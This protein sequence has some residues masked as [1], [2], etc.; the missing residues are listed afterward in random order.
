MFKFK[1]K[2]II[3]SVLIAP[4]I[5]SSFFISSCSNNN[6]ETPSINNDQ[7]I[8][9]EYI[10]NLNPKIKANKVNDVSNTYASE[11]N[12][13]ELV[14]A[15]FDNLP[16]SN[17]EIKVTFISSLPLSSNKGTLEIKYLISKGIYTEVYKYEYSG[18]KVSE[19]TADQEAIMAY[20]KNLNPQIKANKL[21]EIS[22][23]YASEI[24]TEALVQIWFD[25]LPIDNNGIRVTFVSSLDMGNG[26]LEVKYLISKGSYTEIYTF[27]Q[28]GFKIKEDTS[29][30][31]LVDGYIRNLNPTIKTD[32]EQMKASTYASDINSE[33]QLREWFDG[34]PVSNNP[35]Q[36]TYIS[37]LPDTVNETILVVQY[38]IK[39]NNYERIYTFQ[40]MG[41][42]KY[43]TE[44][45]DPSLMNFKQFSEKNSFRMR[46]GVLNRRYIN[47]T[48]WSWYYK[49]HSEYVYDWYLMTNL[50]VVD[51]VVAD[52]QGLLDR[53]GNTTST[54]QLS[55]YYSN[56]F[57]TNYDISSQKHFFDL[58]TYNDQDKFQSI[59]SAWKLQST[60]NA[61]N[62]V[63]QNYIKSIDI[64]TD[65]KNDKIK[66][67][68]ESNLPSPY[69]YYNLDMALVKIS[70]DFKGQYKY[71]NKDYQRPN[72]YEQYLNLINSGSD[73]SI[74]FD[75]N[76]SIAGF[77]LKT[78]S[79]GNESQFVVY[80]SNYSIN[81]RY[82]YINLDLNQSVLIQLKGP[83]YY[84]KQPEANFLL[85]GGASGAAVYQ[86]SNPHEF[87]DYKNIIPI[88]IYWGGISA[89]NSKFLPSFLPFVFNSTYVKYNIFDN[90]KNSLANNQI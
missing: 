43:Q 12:T 15:W 9:K 56:N 72:V 21:S 61:P 83:Y 68:S 82:S 71:L 54:A 63:N 47:G 20:I 23:T 85:S 25:G 40:E 4:I 55:N 34:L 75:K 41:F 73:T 29:D 45:L 19:G 86:P 5:T 16:S 69:S 31:D 35:I 30:Q 46:F 62:V 28:S 52:T 11:I 3:N 49:K 65:F 53:Y 80:N 67:F 90:F 7:E 89:A 48:A 27:T 33:T 10:K 6:V 50:H 8:V 87:L 76:I 14:N 78:P 36:V 37:S 57:I 88:G 60:E 77:P 42:K 51:P 38:K 32:K 59:V 58:M 70:F 17:N 13:E 18:F 44:S 79:Q 22:N 39:S 26:T 74:N 84:L 1:K 81:P 66:L 64:I 24:N 2:L